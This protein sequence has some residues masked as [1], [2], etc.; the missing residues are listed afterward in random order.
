MIFWYFLSHFEYKKRKETR[1][2]S[3]FT[4]KNFSLFSHISYQYILNPIAFSLFYSFSFQ[5]LM[6]F[7]MKNLT[8]KAFIYRLVQKFSIPVYYEFT[9]FILKSNAKIL[10]TKTIKYAIMNVSRKLAYNK[11]RNT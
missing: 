5:I 3:D 9:T 11:K 2:K 8:I 4:K 1:E 6:L 10:L 7:Y